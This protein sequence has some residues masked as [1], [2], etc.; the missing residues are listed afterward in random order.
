MF[1]V[2][3]VRVF[4][5]SG[6]LVDLDDQ[7]RWK[8]RVGLQYTYNSIPNAGRVPSDYMTTFSLVYNRK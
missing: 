7:D 8:L 3:L 5:T 4:S 6:V 1:N 2:E